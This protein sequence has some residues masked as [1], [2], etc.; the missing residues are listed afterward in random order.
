MT[1]NSRCFRICHAQCLGASQTPHNFYY[2]QVAHVSSSQSPPGTFKVALLIL[3]YRYIISLQVRL[4]GTKFKPSE[5]EVIMIYTSLFLVPCVIETERLLAFTI[6][7]QT[8]STL[9]FSFGLACL[10]SCNNAQGILFFSILKW[11]KNIW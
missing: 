2:S 7:C 1:L 5:K 8:V 10:K 9:D 4:Q 3:F 6:G 11:S